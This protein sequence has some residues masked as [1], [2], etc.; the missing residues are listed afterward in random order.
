[1]GEKHL[2]ASREIFNKQGLKG[3]SFGES[4]VCYRGLSVC[5]PGFS[6]PY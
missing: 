2:S 5:S 4:V 3:V 1:M 6:F